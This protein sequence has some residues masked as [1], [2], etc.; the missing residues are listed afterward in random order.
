MYQDRAVTQAFEPGKHCCFSFTHEDANGMTM[1]LARQYADNLLRVLRDGGEPSV[2]AAHRE[3]IL[4]DEL[5]PG[6]PKEFAERIA[7]FDVQQANAA[8]TSG[9]PKGAI[10][11]ES[12]V[13]CMG[14]VMATCVADVDALP[15]IVKGMVAWAEPIMKANKQKADVCAEFRKRLEPEHCVAP[16]Q[17]GGL[18]L[19]LVPQRQGAEAGDD[20]RMRVGALFA[21]QADKTDGGAATGEAAHLSLPLQTMTP[22][23]WVR[24]LCI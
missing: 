4:R 24:R 12:I 22:A 8:F 6:M 9:V 11:V 16:A 3:R 2:T 21:G 14:C 10:R 17:G 23:D 19:L 20:D 5:P 1:E 7:G 15:A 18:Q 13:T